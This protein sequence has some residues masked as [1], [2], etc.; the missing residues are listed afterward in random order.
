MQLR[1]QGVSGGRGG[2]KHFLPFLGCLPSESVPYNVLLFPPASFLL[3][4]TRGSLKDP[5]SLTETPWMF[6]GSIICLL[7]SA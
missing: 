1:C 2:G 3:L 4:A 7:L 6:L 5:P